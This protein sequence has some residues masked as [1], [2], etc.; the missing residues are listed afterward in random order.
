MKIKN[1]LQLA[2]DLFLEVLS[3]LSSSIRNNPFLES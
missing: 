2:E 3:L 1:P